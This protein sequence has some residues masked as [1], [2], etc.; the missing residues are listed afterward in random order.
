MLIFGQYSLLTY[1]YNNMLSE[2]QILQSVQA[3]I[4]LQANAILA[5]QE[6]V[7]ND[8]AAAVS[9]IH[10][11]EGRLVVSG[12]GKSAVIAQKLVATCNSTGTPAIYMHAA[13]A[14]HGDI[15]M[16]LPNDIIIIISKSGMSEE[17]QVLTKLVKKFGNILISITGNTSGYLAME[18][19]FVLNS[20]VEQEAC[21]NNL[22]PTTS[23]TA[24]MVIGD[25]LAICLLQMK[26]FTAADFAKFHPGGALGKQLY[27]Y[28]HHISEQHPKPNVTPE[29]SVNK[30]IISISSNRLGA[31]AVIE[32]KK[33]KGIITDGD[34]RRMLESG[35]NINNLQAKDIMN[36]NPKTISKEEL[37]LAALEQMR[38]NNV[39]QLVVLDKDVFD[40]FIHIHDL[41][42]EGIV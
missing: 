10:H 24:Q 36:P 11:S 3:T 23:T 32:N 14:I 35:Q 33:L 34:L 42:K 5:L 9:A 21:P 38:K 27:T 25:A 28:V 29:D 37:A 31:T 6:L 39:S 15:G 2:S 19:N 12:I 16:L 26:G 22:A 7:T 20:T 18:S 30:V 1:I 8:F 41:L 4:Q 13:D 40:G 17:I